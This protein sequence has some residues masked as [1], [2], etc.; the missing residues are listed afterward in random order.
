MTLK[1]GH[2]DISCL[3]S[4]VSVGSNPSLTT[5][6]S[7]VLDASSILNSL[8]SPGISDFPWINNGNPVNLLPSSQL[9][10]SA[11]SFPF[12]LSSQYPSLNVQSHQQSFLNNFGLS[13]SPL[14]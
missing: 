6:E 10:G 3:Q 9:Q 4:G 5:N 14:I 1:M 2:Q 11:G 7:H 13:L 12:T 8:N